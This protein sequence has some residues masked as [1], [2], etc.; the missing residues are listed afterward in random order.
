MQFADVVFAVIA[1]LLDQDNPF[2]CKEEIEDIYCY[3]MQVLSLVKCRH[4]AR[5][6]GEQVRH[7]RTDQEATRAPAALEKEQEQVI[8]EDERRR[9]VAIKAVIL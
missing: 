1:K 7:R 3:K 8:T 5:T 2:V 6:I 9:C 4:W